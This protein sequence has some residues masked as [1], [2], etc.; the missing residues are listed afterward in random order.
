MI[1]YLLHLTIQNKTLTLTDLEMEDEA[2]TKEVINGNDDR[3]VKEEIFTKIV[4]AGKRTY[5]F[6]RSSNSTFVNSSAV[7][8]SFASICSSLVFST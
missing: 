7:R 5:F 6:P 4:R 1:K 8:V 3:L 2:G